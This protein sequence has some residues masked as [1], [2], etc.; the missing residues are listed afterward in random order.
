MT[1][2]RALAKEDVDPSVHQAMAKQEAALGLVPESLLT[3]AHRP[4]IAAAWGN[5]TGEV[6]GPGTVDRGLKQLVAYMAISAHGCRYCQ[7]HTAHSAERCL[8]G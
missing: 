2:V 7:A 5:L 6:V 8:A 4:G 3:M 1:R